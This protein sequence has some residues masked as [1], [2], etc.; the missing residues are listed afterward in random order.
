MIDKKLLNFFKKKVSLEILFLFF[1]N[2]N[3]KMYSYEIMRKTGCTSRPVRDNIK[4]LLNLGLLEKVVGKYKTRPYFKL[5]RK[6]I[7][8]TRRISEIDNILNKLNIFK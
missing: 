8:V 4:L 5:S 1:S 7:E 3:K 2:L 6:G